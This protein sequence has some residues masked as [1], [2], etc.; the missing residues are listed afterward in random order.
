MGHRTELV[1]L[2][3]I[4]GL[5][6]FS[7]IV[8]GTAPTGCA[9]ESTV[10]RLTHALA[11]GEARDGQASPYLLP[12]LE[13]LAQAQLQGGAL[14]EAAALRRRALDI[15]VAVFGCDSASAA[16]AMAALALVDIERRR[17]LDAE[18]LLIVAASV[19]AERAAADHPATATIFAGLARIALARGDT[20]PA[21]TWA[22]NALAIARR[23]P[24][25]RSA[26][27]LRTLGAV[28]AAEGRFA[29]AEQVL[30]EALAQDKKQHGADGIDTAR[31]LSQLGNLYL[32]QGRT[33]DA[34]PLL[35]EAAAIDQ[36][37][38]GPTH[39]AIADDLHDLGL[40][41]SA[42]NRGKEARAAFNTAIDILERGAGK[43]TPRVA[44]AELE[45][46][47]L[48]RQAGDEAAAEAAFRDARRILNKEEAEEH[49]RER[50]V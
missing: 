9:D 27:P 46:S 2:F 31:S 29:E 5:V 42:L 32:R 30:T 36:T 26:E 33:K 17:Y 34:L 50:E 4:A 6:G 18:P 11:A 43:E 41:Y 37:R 1:G 23:N 21:E 24:H 38:L 44:Y 15:A 16:A 3:R 35:D 47:R 7:L 10:A 28:L 12:V 25:G 49:K 20:K 39:P 8:L 22:T 45:L 13:E 14:G 48:Y 40:A 19:L